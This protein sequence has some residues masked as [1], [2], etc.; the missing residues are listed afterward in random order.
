MNQPANED[1]SRTA[2]KYFTN[3]A[4]LVDL[5]ELNLASPLALP[6]INASRG[7]H[8]SP[9]GWETII[10]TDYW[11]WIRSGNVSFRRMSDSTIEIGGVS[12][13]KLDVEI[14]VTR[15]GLFSGGS[16]WVNSEAFVILKI[17]HYE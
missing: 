8:Y 15:A 7:L 4:A 2:C 16:L 1:K 17:V 12:L 9:R 13:S 10:C 11:T 14:A 5:E 6:L 3:G